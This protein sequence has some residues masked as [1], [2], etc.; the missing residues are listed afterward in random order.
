MGNCEDIDAGCF[1]AVEDGER[2]SA[3]RDPPN[4][5]ALLLPGMRGF[6]Q[7]IEHRLYLVAQT[8]REAAC[9]AGVEPDLVL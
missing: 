9:T 5:S 2:K 8:P 3:N 4:I 6:G 1:R 7:K